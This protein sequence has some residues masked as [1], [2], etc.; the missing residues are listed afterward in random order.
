MG[1]SNIRYADIIIDISHEALDKVFQY[2]VP[3]S[4]WEEVRPGSR[5][6]VPFGR[7]NRETEGYVIAIRQEADYEESKIKEILRVNTEGIS[8]ESEL[9]QVASF[10]KEKY[11]STMIQ[12]LRTVLPVK[13]KMKPK[14]EVFITL[15]IEKDTAQQLLCEWERKHFAA[16]A[17]FLST[18]LKKERMRKEE[19]VKRCNFPLKELRKLSEQ[20]I[21]KL[22][23]RIKYR[24]PFPK[25][26]TRKQGW[27]LNDE[28]R[29]IV[30]NFKEEYRKEERRTYL[31]YG[32]TGS[33]K[34]EVYLSLI[35]EVLAAGRQVI[36]LIPEISLTYQ[37]VRRFYERFG[38]R[39]AVINSRMSK[40][41]KSDACERIRAGEADVIIG[42]RSALF[43][44]T[45][46]LGLI[47]I[48]EEHD[49][50]YKSDTSPKYHARETAIY[51]AKLCGASVVLGSAT[52]SVEAYAHALNGEYQLW[53]LKKRAG[54]AI[55]PK[56]Q[57]V[58][59]R[60]EFKKGNRSIFSEELHK[61]IT[62]CLERKEQIMLFL[63]RRGFAGFVSCRACGQVI[64]C[65]HCDVTLTYHRNGKLRCH[66]CGH[67]EVF[68]KQCPICKSPHVAAFGLGTEK[69]EAALHQEFPA[70]RVL[71]MDM[72]TTKRKH[73][74]EEMLAAFAA[75]KADIL[76]GT[77]MIVK[78]HDYANVTLVGI[79]AADLSLHEQDFRSGEKTFQLLCQAA[80]RAGRGEKAGNVIIQTYSPE[81]Y[82]IVAAARH[83]YENFFK[84]EY[85]YRKLMAYPPCAH[86]LVIL[87]Q[88]GDESQS[89][90]A[91]L[92]IEKIIEQSQ[93]GES[94]PIQ[95]L[96]PGQASLS[97]LKDVY[98]QVLYL[99]HKE[100]E[101]LLDLKRR[102]EPVLEKHPMFAGISIQF[103]FDPLSHY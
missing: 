92:R 60:E 62:E 10:L 53:T 46:R 25:L 78:G 17:R 19:A 96:N 82:A 71:R 77:Q 20:G 68:T 12:A 5:V 35:N 85:T 58:D 31:L 101:R 75:G 23:S 100:E 66:Y 65:P 18:L 26:V 1:D 67:E 54:N 90:I 42:A 44:P 61:K 89:I 24:N 69:V 103:D 2:R 83:S 72:D 57:I 95:I 14:E 98:R 94:N 102:L 50:A 7:G 51:R 4:L 79:L 86:M 52:P 76:L 59:L 56:T 9:I 93:S 48:D 40:G 27:P 73:A 84:E 16:R 32:I 11:G 45:E 91:M 47:V 15:S 39:I 41:E 38:E 87:I 6:F 55:L 8:V 74:H 21:I 80:G 43:A 37:T 29:A 36:V 88:S 34:T 33:G 97:K 81:H 28:Q 3:L 30:D 64:K 49:G 99:K 22:E 70:A 63:N 13:T